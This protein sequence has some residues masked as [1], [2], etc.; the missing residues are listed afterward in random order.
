MF[1][2]IVSHLLYFKYCRASF[3]SREFYFL[4]SPLLNFPG[5][6]QHVLIFHASH[7]VIYLLHIPYTTITQHPIY[8]IFME[9]FYIALL[10][11]SGGFNDSVCE[12]F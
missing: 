3:T 1:C 5:T 7:L 12:Q 10:P 8:H 6:Q 2:K 11:P 9:Y 4:L